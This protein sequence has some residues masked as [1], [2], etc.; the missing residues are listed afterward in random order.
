MPPQTTHWGAYSTPTD[1]LTVFKGS[2]SQ[3][4]TNGTVDTVEGKG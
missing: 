4:K 3:Q 1:P 2:A